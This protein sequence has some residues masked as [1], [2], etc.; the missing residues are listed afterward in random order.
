MRFFLDDERFPP[1]DDWEQWHIE[2]T[3]ESAMSFMEEH[4]CPSF[5][6]F[7]HDLGAGLNGYDL[8]HWM[9]ERDLDMRGAFI[10]ADFSFYVHSQNSVGV[11][12]I[13]SLLDNYL[14]Q[15]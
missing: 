10:P 1:G 2:R 6:S 7:D 12:N 11:V 5:I 4:G 3:A 14:K 9:V 13:R 15:R 8:A